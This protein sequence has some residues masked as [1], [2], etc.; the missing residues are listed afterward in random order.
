MNR[1]TS[2]K[3]ARPLR[4]VKSATRTYFEILREKLKWGADFV[5]PPVPTITRR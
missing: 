4:I 3:Q 2:I 5:T 1:Q